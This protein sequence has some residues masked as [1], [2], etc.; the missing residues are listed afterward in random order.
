MNS[1]PAV[2]CV[3]GAMECLPGENPG[4]AKLGGCFAGTM[5][6]VM[7]H[8]T[9]RAGVGPEF[10]SSTSVRKV[11]P[12]KKTNLPFVPL[13]YARNCFFAVALDSLTSKYVATHNRKVK[14]ARTAVT[15]TR[16]SV[17]S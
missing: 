2:Q 8:L 9:S 6:P 7:A 4:S 12:G 1:Y 10:R 17:A 14:N 16:C 15:Q 13:R 5:C 11:C 3:L